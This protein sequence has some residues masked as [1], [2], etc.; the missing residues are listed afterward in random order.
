MKRKDSFSLIELLIVIGILSIIVTV[1]SVNLFSSR[2]R[3]ALEGQINKTVADLRWTMDRSR[4]QEAGEGWGIH[5]ENPSGGDSDD[6]Y[7][8]W[9]GASYISSTIVSTINL[10]RGTKFTDPSSGSSEDITFSKA[11]GLPTA[12][13]TITIESTIGVG[14]GI[15]NIN[16]YGKVD[17]SIN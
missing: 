13:A 12:D 3:N 10:A 4:S 7:E 15:I 16:S 11:T 17:Y 6:F 2:N 14:V 8:I 5:F 1:G 9:R